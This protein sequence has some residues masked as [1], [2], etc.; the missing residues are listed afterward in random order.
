MKRHECQFVFAVAEEGS[1]LVAT[2]SLE[3]KPASSIEVG[4]IPARLID[5]RPEM[6]ERWRDLMTEGGVHIIESI[7]GVPVTE[8]GVLKNESRWHTH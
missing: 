1:W 3:D 4:R 8:V 5:E 7:A 2:V 6:W